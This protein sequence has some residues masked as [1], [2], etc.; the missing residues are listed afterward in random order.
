MFYSCIAV[1]RLSFL[2]SL[3]D[4]KK[5]ELYFRKGNIWIAILF[6]EHRTG[7]KVLCLQKCMTTAAVFFVSYVHVGCTLVCA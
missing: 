5:L 1:D 3:D 4:Y 2:M 7:D 6:A